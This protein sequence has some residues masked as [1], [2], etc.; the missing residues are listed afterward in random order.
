[1]SGAEVR[2]RTAATQSGSRRLP[3]TVREA[4]GRHREE[5]AVS[6]WRARLLGDR[7]RLGW[8][9][10]PVFALV[11][12]AGAV[13]AGA[14]TS[15]Y[16]GQ[17]VDALEAETRG[18]REEAQA[19]AQEV[20]DAR[21]EALSEIQ[22]QL[23]RVR[24]SLSGE[25]P[26]DDVPASGIV[27]IRAFVGAPSAAAPGTDHDGTLA[28]VQESPSPREPPSPQ[29]SA[30]VAPPPG[31]PAPQLSER[32]GSGFAVAVENGVGFFVT[33][34]AVVADP[35]APGGVAQRV[36]VQTPNG[37]VE[38]AIHSW[39]AGR[40]LALIRAATGELPI[41][42]W[43]RS[44]EPLAP[45]ARIV[46][47][48]VTPTLDGVQLEGSV[49]MADVGVLITDLPSIGYLRGAPIVDGQGLV[50]GVFSTDYAPFGPAGGQRQGSVPVQLLCER[51]L[52]SCESLEAD[53][54][55]EPSE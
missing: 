52:R 43:R 49:A 4:R 25:L 28:A 17:Q 21:D 24:D 3:R 47:A 19:A 33:T 50:I 22:V 9:T 20:L 14:L 15:V 40:D 12:L 38:G 32:V 44:D 41:P 30:T 7:D 1:M 16:Y 45:G 42:L 10:L 8:W 48:G 18:A 27:L 13:L 11:G 5:G 37:R 46:L 39:D 29:P 23:D 31:Q 34:H 54:T 51:M 53:P 55:E 26:F 6:Q 2:R 35:T 36:E